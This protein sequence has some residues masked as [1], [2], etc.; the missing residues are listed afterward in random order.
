[1]KRLTLVALLV[2]SFAA[3]ACGRGDGG[4]SGI[5]VLENVNQAADLHLSV[6]GAKSARF[7]GGFDLHILTAD[8]PGEDA[9]LVVGTAGPLKISDDT[10]IEAFVQITNYAGNGTYTAPPA[11]G[12]KVSFSNNAYVQFVTMDAAG[13]PGLSRYD[14]VRETCR[15]EV[16][17]QGSEGSARCAALESDTGGRV[18]LRMTWKASGERR[19]I[20]TTTAPGDGST[21]T[22]TVPTS[23]PPHTSAP[24]EAP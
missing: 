16:K 4:D 7:E 11:K 20:T 8:S 23:N 2:A 21:T 13:V 19:P 5:P 24:G 15:F 18:A 22:T 14:I 1:M 6:S 9:V 3:G 12:E 17:R 10:T